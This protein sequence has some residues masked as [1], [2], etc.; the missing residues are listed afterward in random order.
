MN[1]VKPKINSN[2]RNLHKVGLITRDISIKLHFHRYEEE[3]D[4]Y[5][6][7]CDVNQEKVNI[8]PYL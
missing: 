4:D 5:D 2:S 8:G 3:D 1:Y 6:V 7:E